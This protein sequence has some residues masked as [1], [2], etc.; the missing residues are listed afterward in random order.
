MS[1]PTRDKLQ[2]AGAVGREKPAEELELRTARSHRAAP[3]DCSTAICMHSQQETL[4]PLTGETELREDL[5]G[6]FHIDNGVR[7]PPSLPPCRGGAARQGEKPTSSENPALI[8]NALAWTGS[9]AQH[10]P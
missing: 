3:P 6:I 7:L 10:A 5:H 9:P 4:T 8:G 2:R 1:Q